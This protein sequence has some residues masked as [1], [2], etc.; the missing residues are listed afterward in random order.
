M[1]VKLPLF[2]LDEAFF[3]EINYDIEHRWIHTGIESM[4]NN[5]GSN[6]LIVC[7]LHEKS[8]D[9][10]RKVKQEKDDEWRRRKILRLFLLKAIK[11]IKIE[12]I[13]HLSI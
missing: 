9:E 11:V 10:A 3:E 1:I 12:E 8:A 4:F 7:L 2:N 13:F 6:L 5:N